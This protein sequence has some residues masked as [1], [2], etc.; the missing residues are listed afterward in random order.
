MRAFLFLV[1]LL[2]ALVPARAALPPGAPELAV[3]NVME[4]APQTRPRPIVSTRKLPPYPPMAV[5]QGEQGFTKLRVTLGADGAPT[6]VAVVQS[7]GVQQLDDSAVNTVQTEWRWEPPG[8]GCPAPLTL[9]VS[10]NWQ[11]KDRPNA[12]AGIDPL[13]LMSVLSII[14]PDDADYPADALA[15]KQRGLTGLLVALSDT[16]QA[17]DVIVS[18]PSGSDSLDQKAV[19]LAKDKFRWAA[20][21]LNGKPIGGLMVVMVVWTLPGQPKPDT[22]GLKTLIELMIKART[23]QPRPESSAP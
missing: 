17:Q 2:F 9:D 4:C 11:L 22:A 3:R 7:S 19:Q 5:R 10:V 20:P 13:R 12:L 15:Q 18:T 1:P 23:A 21:A 6:A 16:G 14:A 8:A